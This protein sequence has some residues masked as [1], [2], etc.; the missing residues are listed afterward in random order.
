MVL[1]EYEE[2]QKYQAEKYKQELENDKVP[3][4]PHARG[5]MS[6]CREWATCALA[7]SHLRAISDH[8]SKEEGGNISEPKYE[9]Q[10][11]DVKVKL[12]F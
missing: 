2:E 10:E 8:P 3:V 7:S 1:Q 9:A 4:E 12:R 6:A 11:N 5:P